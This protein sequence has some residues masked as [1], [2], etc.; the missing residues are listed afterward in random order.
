MKIETVT[1]AEEIDYKF[2]LFFIYKSEAQAPE[3]VHDTCSR[4]EEL[5]KVCG[6]H[7]RDFRVGVAISDNTVQCVRT[8]RKIVV[9]ITPQFKESEW[10]K[11][12]LGIA[13]DEKIHFGGTRIIPVFLNITAQEQI[14]HA[15]R[16]FTGLDVSGKPEEWWQKFMK[17]VVESTEDP[18]LLMEYHAK[19]L[20]GLIKE[21]P[22]KST[23]IRTEMQQISRHSNFGLIS[24]REPYYQTKT[25]GFRLSVVSNK[26]YITVDALIVIALCLCFGK[27]MSAMYHNR[28][29]ELVLKVLAILFGSLTFVGATPTSGRLCIANMRTLNHFL[30]FEIAYACL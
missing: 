14:P 20:L 25:P 17:T 5:G 16:I 18:S 11:Y 15:L 27:S 10:C 4:L 28:I 2:D 3:W 8:S 24:K 26:S 22:N 29:I 12:D 6:Y 23:C 13:L 1:S 9:I 21:Y 7:E 19:K 30:L